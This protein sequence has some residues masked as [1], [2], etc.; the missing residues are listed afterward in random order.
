MKLTDKFKQHEIEW[1][2]MTG[3]FKN[4]DE[5]QPWAIILPYLTSRAIMNRLDDAI[6]VEN[7]QDHYRQLEHGITCS[8]SLRIKNEW[9]TKEDGASE[10]EIDSFKGGLSDAFKRAAVKWGMG[11]YL[12]EL[13]GPYFAQFKKQNENFH[14]KTKITKNSKYFRWSPPEIP[15][16]YD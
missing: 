1:R 12:Y 5:S 7:W 3:G 8:L 4:N 9:I 11:R 15:D 13:K 10:T 14:Y 16:L 2:I 6:G